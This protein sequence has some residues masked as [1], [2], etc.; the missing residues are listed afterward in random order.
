M[1]QANS[2]FTVFIY[3]I[4]FKVFIS[5]V[6]SSS[7]Y[8]CLLHAYIHTQPL[9]AQCLNDPTCAIILKRISN[10][11]CIKYEGGVD[12]VGGV[13]DLVNVVGSLVLEGALFLFWTFVIHIENT[14]CKRNRLKR[15]FGRSG[16]VRRIY[17]RL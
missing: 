11:P 3:F 14:F 8:P 4:Y 5:S 7:V 9:S 6:R 17:R 16:L 2:D 10:F 15:P 1:V 12:D 13:K